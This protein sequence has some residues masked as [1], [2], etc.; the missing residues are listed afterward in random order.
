MFQI[1]TFSGLRDTSFHPTPTLKHKYV[2]GGYNGGISQGIPFN[3]FAHFNNNSAGNAGLFST[4]DNLITY[5]QL[6]LNKGKMPS[7]ARVF[8]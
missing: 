8:S 2:P 3:K 1:L 6:I 4:V 7:F 5:M